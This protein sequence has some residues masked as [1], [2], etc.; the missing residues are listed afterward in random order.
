MDK[1]DLRKNSEGYSDPTVYNAFKN[2]EKEGDED[3]I[4]SWIQFSR[5]VSCRGSILRREL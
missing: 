3:S 4:N 1:D 2:M 5:F